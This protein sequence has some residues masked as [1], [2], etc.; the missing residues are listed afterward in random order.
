MTHSQFQSLFGGPSP[1]KTKIS[2]R[3]PCLC[4]KAYMRPNY[5]PH[6]AK[7]LGR[8]EKSSCG[9]GTAGLVHHSAV[10]PPIRWQESG[11]E[12]IS[13][14]TNG[15]TQS[16]GPISHQEREEELLPT[17]QNITKITMEIQGQDFAMSLPSR[18]KLNSAGTSRFCSGTSS[19]WSLYGSTLAGR[20]QLLKFLN[21][22]EQL[23]EA[24]AC[25]KSTAS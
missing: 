7:R 21:F 8:K 25:F 1:G 19:L 13:F 14:T 2:R 11:K 23:L 6:E 20:L 17:V 10:L 9:G 4:G 24:E 5:T 12:H 16:Y 18:H 3:T 22:L 15:K